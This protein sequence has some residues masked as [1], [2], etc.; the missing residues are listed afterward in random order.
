[1]L[2][3]QKGGV[4]VHT[5]LDDYKIANGSRAFAVNLFETMGNCRGTITLR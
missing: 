5:H 2:N 1:M 4:V 3:D